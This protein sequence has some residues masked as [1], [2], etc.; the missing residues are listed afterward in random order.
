MSVAGVVMATKTVTAAH[1][2]HDQAQGQRVR[3]TVRPANMPNI[4][5]IVTPTYSGTDRRKQGRPVKVSSGG[6][7]FAYDANPAESRQL[8]NATV[9]NMYMASAKD[10]AAACF[11]IAA[12]VILVA[13]AAKGLSNPTHSNP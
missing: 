1:A 12:A 9:F 2:A 11:S 4:T 3:H 8:V 13:A 10:C 6:Y 7:E 5:T